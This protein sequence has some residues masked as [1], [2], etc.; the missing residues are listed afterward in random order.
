M[1]VL[2]FSKLA[3]AVAP[4]PTPLAL[5]M[6]TVGVVLYPVPALVS[7]INETLLPPV[8]RKDVAL[9]CIPLA[10]FGAEITTE[11]ETL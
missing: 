9:A 10:L 4:L 7:A 11:G 2:K 8:V 1:P 5:V 6:V 3:T